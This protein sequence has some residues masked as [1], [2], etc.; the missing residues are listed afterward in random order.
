MPAAVPTMTEEEL[1]Q[2]RRQLL[3]GTLFEPGF[4]RPRVEELLRAEAVDGVVPHGTYGRVAERAGSSYAYVLTIA[5]E[6]RLT[7]GPQPPRSDRQRLWPGSM[8]ADGR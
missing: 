5:G 2:W 4:L 3:L 7:A 8:A 1:R 6:L